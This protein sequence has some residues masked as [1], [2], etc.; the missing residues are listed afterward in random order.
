MMD[1]ERCLHCRIIEAIREDSRLLYDLP[2]DEQDVIYN[3]EHIFGHMMTVMAEMLASH[4]DRKEWDRRT[5]QIARGIRDEIPRI[6]AKGAG[7]Y[8][9]LPN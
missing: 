8:P 7:F 4:P 3:I 2:K 5:K 6:R 1:D 9:R